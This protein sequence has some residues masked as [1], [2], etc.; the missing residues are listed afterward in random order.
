V[1]AQPEP[2]AP[3]WAVEGGLP[4]A[5][6][7][8]SFEDYCRRIGVEEHEIKQLTVG[9]TAR[10]ADLANAR[11]GSYL[12]RAC[13]DA[14]QAALERMSIP[15]QAERRQPRDADEVWLDRFFQRDLR[16]ATADAT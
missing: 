14:Y 5:A 13:P 7:G 1:T 8:E 3:P 10:T 11:L 6:K 4:P 12:I 2:Y 9:L 16:R 15:A